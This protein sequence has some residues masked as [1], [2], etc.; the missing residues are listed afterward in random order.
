MSPGGPVAP[1]SWNCADRSPGRSPNLLDL[2]PGYRPSVSRA[3][4]RCT[5]RRTHHPVLFDVH[6][7]NWNVTAERSVIGM[8]IRTYRRKGATKSS[9]L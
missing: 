6:D 4:A 1:S 5:G 3:E 9:T 2:P 7:S 8:T